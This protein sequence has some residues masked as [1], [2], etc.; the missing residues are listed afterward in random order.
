MALPKELLA[1][2][3]TVRAPAFATPGRTVKPRIHGLYGRGKSASIYFKM[4]LAAIKTAR[5]Q[6]KSGY[7]GF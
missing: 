6:L 1:Q 3:P 2:T 7:G 5:L 4:L